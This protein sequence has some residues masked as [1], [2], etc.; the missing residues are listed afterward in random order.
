MIKAYNSEITKI[1]EKIRQEEQIALKKRREE[2]ELK[3]PKVIDIEKQIGKLC[4]NLSMNMLKDMENRDEYLNKLKKSITELRVQKSELLVQHGYDMDYLD[5]KY[6]CSKCKDTGFIGTVR[7]I[8]YKPKLVQVYYENSELKDILSTNNFDY[9]RF[10]YYSTQKNNGEPMSPRKNMEKVVSNVQSYINNF[11][12]ST[13]NFLFFGSSGTGKT[14]LSNCIAKELLDKGYLVVYRT[15]EDL[16]QNLKQVRF[17]N[18]EELENLLINCD[19]LI[20][21]DLGTEQISEF[22]KMELFNIINKKLLK[23]KKMLLSTNFN[24][25]DL[26]KIYTERITSRLIGD[27]TQCKFYG[28]DIRLKKKHL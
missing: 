9:F 19:L 22:S 13:E 4:L 10:D 16:I 25:E 8:C 20:V 17:N 3:L 1:Y 26:F 14:F 7:C 18:N 5:M 12:S 23:H 24:L 6:R 2:I 21:D 27:F 11:A 28:E 15:A